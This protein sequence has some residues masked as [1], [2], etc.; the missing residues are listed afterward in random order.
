MSEQEK[1]KDPGLGWLDE[2]L[3]TYSQSGIYPFHMPGHKRRSIDMEYADFLGKT[4]NTGNNNFHEKVAETSN[5]FVEKP[6]ETEKDILLQT[7]EKPRKVAGNIEQIDITEIDGFDNLHHPEGILKAAQQRMARICGADQ[8]FFL[9]NGSTAGLLAAISAAVPRGGKILLARNCHKAAY[10]A[11]FLRQLQVTYLYP[12]FTEFGIQGSILPEQ[13][14]EVLAENPGIQAVLLTSP[15]YDGV[16]SDIRSISRIVHG[17]GIPLIVDEA[18]GAHFGFGNRFPEK[19]LAQGADLVIESM[20]KTLPSYTQTAAL[21]LMRGYVDPGEVQR[22]LGIYQSSSPSYIFMAGLDRCMRFMEQHGRETLEQHGQRLEQFYE[23]TAKLQCLEVLHSCEKGMFD[24]DASKI[25]I[26][27]RHCGISGQTLS[28]M[29]LHRFGL[30]MEMASGH[31]VTALTSLMDTQEGFDRLYE[32]LEQIEQEQAQRREL[33][34]KNPGAI[35]SVSTWNPAKSEKA[36]EAGEDVKL[37]EDTKFVN[38]EDTK[39]ETNAEFIKPEF[40]KYGKPVEN[41]RF[42]EHSAP[43]KCIASGKEETLV[44]WKLQMEHLYQPGEQKMEIWQAQEA[45]LEELE[46][47]AAAGRI[48]GEFVYLYPPGIPFLVPGERI[49]EEL[50]LELTKL[51]DEGFDVEG[52]ADYSCKMI[53]VVRES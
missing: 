38:A 9:V 49:P 24:R 33:L 44:D 41:A 42:K 5:M 32:A 27:G 28:Q 50:P 4:A 21:H 17:Y 18:H 47:Q 2:A 19:A 34:E 11:C 25:L 46:L 43:E 53:R 29:L 31:Y 20:H 22:Y 7:T 23:K 14:G 48:S 52:L 30:Q 40:E 3:E 10:H 8:S 16:V 35:D 39:F 6:G 12:A 26:S 45:P 36:S 51:Q 1:Y 13:V 37:E 15:T